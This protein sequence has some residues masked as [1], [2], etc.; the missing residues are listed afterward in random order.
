M[1]DLPAMVY[2]TPVFY[3]FKTVTVGQ[4]KVCKCEWDGFAVIIFYSTDLVLFDVL[5]FIA[6]IVLCAAI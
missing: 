5:P 2:C 4:E 3:Y 1:G 6:I